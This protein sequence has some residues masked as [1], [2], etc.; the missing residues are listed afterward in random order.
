MKGYKRPGAG[1]LKIPSA[2]IPL[3]ALGKSSDRFLIPCLP[4]LDFRSDPRGLPV[5][6]GD[7]VAGDIWTLLKT[8]VWSSASAFPRLVLPDRPPAN[9]F[10]DRSFTADS[11]AGLKLNANGRI[12]N[13]NRPRGGH[14]NPLPRPD[15]RLHTS[16]HL[17]GSQS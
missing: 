10:S 13:R 17:P 8:A 14:G 5:V 4:D 1:T 16:I 7:I 11:G 9:A 2:I 3:S 15:A 6:A 12:D